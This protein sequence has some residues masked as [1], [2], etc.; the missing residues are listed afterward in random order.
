MKTILI[1]S[2]ILS[3]FF[4]GIHILRTWRMYRVLQLLIIQKSPN[5]L[6]LFLYEDYYPLSND[7]AVYSSE[8]EANQAY[9]Y[10]YGDISE[11]TL[12]E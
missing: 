5:E 6:A 3:M 12:N 7:L 1:M 9:N 11:G 2:G 10:Y 4:T 8:K